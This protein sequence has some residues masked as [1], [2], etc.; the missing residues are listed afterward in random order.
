MWSLMSGSLD[1]KKKY[2][3][4]LLPFDKQKNI[5]RVHSQPQ[6]AKDPSATKFQLLKVVA[7]EQVEL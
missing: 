1:R 2:H 3:W 4:N 6:R 5:Q 7:E